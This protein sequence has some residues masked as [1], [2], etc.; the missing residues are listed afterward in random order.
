MEGSKNVN[1]RLWKKKSRIYIVLLITHI[2][3]ILF[4]FK[5]S[6]TLSLLVSLFASHKRWYLTEKHNL[7]LYITWS[8]KSRAVDV[9]A[10]QKLLLSANP[11]FLK[12][13][14]AIFFK[15]LTLNLH[16]GNFLKGQLVYQTPILLFSW[17]Q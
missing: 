14:K 4:G 16:L 10:T 15:S 6:T 8:R 11:K 17:F 9:K 5:F 1:N 2:C 3:V 13:I 7:V 12:G